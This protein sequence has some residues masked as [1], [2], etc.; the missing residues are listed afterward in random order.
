MGINYSF[1]E[2]LERSWRVQDFKV[3]VAVNN[4]KPPR[5]AALQSLWCEMRTQF[6]RKLSRNETTPQKLNFRMKL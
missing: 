2:I 5:E 6:S 3:C 1:T 4:I